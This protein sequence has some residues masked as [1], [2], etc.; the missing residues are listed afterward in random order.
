MMMKGPVRELLPIG[1]QLIRVRLPEGTQPAK[2][3]LLT[4]GR[5]LRAKRNGRCLSLAVPTILDHE[6]VAIDLLAS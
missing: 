1:E 2:T 6:V 4:N 3:R 5:P